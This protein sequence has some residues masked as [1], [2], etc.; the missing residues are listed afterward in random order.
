MKTCKDCQHSEQIPQ[1]RN[2]DYRDTV[3]RTYCNKARINVGSSGN[4]ENLECFE[5]KK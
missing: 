3:M 2:G 1:L 4:A 5:E